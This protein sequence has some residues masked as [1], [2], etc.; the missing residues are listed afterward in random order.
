M[1]I[2]RPIAYRELHEDEKIGSGNF[3]NPAPKR[4]LIWTI[5]DIHDQNITL[6]IEVFVGDLLENSKTI[7]IK[8]SVAYT[9]NS[10]V[11]GYSPFWIDINNN[12]ENIPIDGSTDNPLLGEYVELDSLELVGG[13]RNV[14]HYQSFNNHSFVDEIGSTRV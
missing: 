4:K 6:K 1:Y 2:F 7:I 10:T 12:E 14:L 5:V 11:L 3:L 13:I 9:I 8:D